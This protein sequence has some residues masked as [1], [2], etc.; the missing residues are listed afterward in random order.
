MR[1]KPLEEI[2]LE[3]QVG[4]ALEC[5]R[6]NSCSIQSVLFRITRLISLRKVEVEPQ[7]VPPINASLSLFGI[8]RQLTAWG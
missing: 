5:L 3:V 2:E 1:L 6:P 8:K 7:F 4:Q